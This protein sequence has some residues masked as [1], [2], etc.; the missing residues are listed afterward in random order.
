MLA[1]APATIAITLL[2]WILPEAFETEV[3]QRK[4]SRAC[5][6]LMLVAM[7]SYVILG[8]QSAA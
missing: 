1:I 3:G 8:F 5:F 6:V 4:A 7:V 2:G